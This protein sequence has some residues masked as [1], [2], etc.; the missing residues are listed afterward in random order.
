MTEPHAEQVLIRIEGRLGHITL[1]RPRQINALTFD[2]VSAVRAA[3]AGWQSDDQVQLVLIDGAGERGLCAG[4]DIKLLHQGLSGTA[5]SVT[6]AFTFLRDEYQMN[7]ALAHYPKPVIAYLDGLTLGGGLGISGHDSVRIV[8][9]TSQLG[10]PETAIGLCPD[11]GVLHLYARAPGELGTHAALTGSRFGPGDAIAAGLA[12]HFVP[13]ASLAGLTE[14]LRTGVVPT[15]EAA[16]PPPGELFA[17][18]S[19]IDSCYAGND[20][21]AIVA[22]LQD[23]PEAAA[24]AAAEVLGRMSPT[25]LKVTLQAIRRAASQTVDEVLE[26][27]LRVASRFLLHPDLAEGIRAQVIDK[28]RRPRWQPA[29]LTEVTGEQVA[30]FFA[31]LA[32]PVQRLESPGQS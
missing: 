32:G 21:E 1:N 11:V 22:A 15:F 8:T 27:D 12:D 17:G 6:G 7:S 18:R 29:S 30:A 31:P 13:A 16:P 26:Q 10:M 28:D 20:V 2:M 25:A 9:E 19:W 23:R 4:A 3:L 14:Q 24:Q 5:G